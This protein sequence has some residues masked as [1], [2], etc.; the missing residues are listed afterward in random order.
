MLPLRHTALTAHKGAHSQHTSA[1]LVAKRPACSMQP[2]RPASGLHPAPRNRL[3]AVLVTSHMHKACPEP[4]Q[5]QQRLT[6]P[7]AAAR[8][9]ERQRQGSPHACAPATHSRAH[10]AQ[11]KRSTY[12][13]GMVA[14][15]S[16]PPASSDVRRPRRTRK[17]VP[18]SPSQ[19]GRACPRHIT[20]KDPYTQNEQTACKRNGKLWLPSWRR[21]NVQR[22]LRHR[23]AQAAM[24]CVAHHR[25]VC[26]AGGSPFRTWCCSPSPCPP[27]H[28]PPGPSH[29]LLAG[30]LKLTTTVHV[31]LHMHAHTRARQHTPLTG[32][33]PPPKKPLTPLAAPA[34][35]P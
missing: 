22:G 21:W 17:R 23:V 6:H 2:S 27:V 33:P 1:H 30:T 13:K 9:Q 20:Q 35:A 15:P 32:R 10:H 31:Q 11:A 5:P 8:Q 28:T 29:N 3:R 19:K 34:L 18:H 14:G 4:S 26:K 16:N 7:H 24:G 25:K 12:G